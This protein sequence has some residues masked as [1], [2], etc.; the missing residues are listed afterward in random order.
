MNYLKYRIRL[1]NNNQ[2]NNNSN[3]KYRIII[4]KKYEINL[5]F[6]VKYRICTYYNLLTKFILIF[7]LKIKF[8]NNKI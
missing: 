7:N 6:I 1:N 5:N 4:I 3:K 2:I 8:S